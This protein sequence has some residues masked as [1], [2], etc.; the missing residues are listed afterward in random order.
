M[1]A[2]VLHP[3]EMDWPSAGKRLATRSPAIPVSTMAVLELLGRAHSLGG[4]DTARR[5][6]RTLD[7]VIL[8]KNSKA[9]RAGHRAAGAP[10][11]RRRIAD[12]G[13]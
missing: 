6:A 9:G 3:A 5:T 2:S 11:M 7:K 13:Y 10:S 12:A 8:T 1:G 4:N